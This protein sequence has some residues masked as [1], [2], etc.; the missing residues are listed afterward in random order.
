MPAKA[1]ILARL[2]RDILSLQG[3]KAVSENDMNAVGLERINQSFPHGVFPTA[4]VHEFFCSGNEDKTASAA[5]ITGLLSS[6]M[7][8][9][10][11]A[12]WIGATRK[13]FPPALQMF[14]VRPKQV[15]FLDLKKEKEISWAVEEALKC[16]RGSSR[17]WSS[18]LAGKPAQ[19]P[20]WETR[21]L[22]HRMDRRA[23]SPCTE[24]CRYSPGTAK[25][26]RL[27]WQSVLS[28]SGSPI[29]LPT[30]M[31]AS[32]QNCVMWPLC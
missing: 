14:G 9:G 32:N 25:E 21:K 2:Q 24:A 26:N 12:L 13:I 3:F 10:G 8:R 19:G 17:C 1:D 15:I 7:H 22:G 23:I 18:P 4:A 20:Q 28:H 30:G 11:A 6:L 16:R 31:P 5:F 27:I 29:L